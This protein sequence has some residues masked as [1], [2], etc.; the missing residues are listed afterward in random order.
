MSGEAVWRGA[1]AAAAAAGDRQVAAASGVIAARAAALP[2]IVATV[3][4]DA[5]VLSGQG[6]LARAFGSRRRA[7]D[8]RLAGLASGDSA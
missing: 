6:L 8:P 3:E 7:A 5:V 2:G 1:W 4:R